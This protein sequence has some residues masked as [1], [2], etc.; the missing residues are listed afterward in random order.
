MQDADDV[1]GHGERWRRRL[2]SLLDLPHGWQCV[3]LLEHQLDEGGVVV[4]R[5]GGVE[6][7]VAECVP[8]LLGEAR[9]VNGGEGADQ[10]GADRFGHFRQFGCAGG[11]DVVE[12]GAAD[13]KLGKETP[14]G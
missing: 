8:D 12:V 14:T 13:R 2:L 10:D 1:G 9:L 5:Q 3:V 6:F 11:D 7:G 4:Q